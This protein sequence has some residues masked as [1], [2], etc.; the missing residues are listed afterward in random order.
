MSDL[1]LEIASKSTLVKEKPKNKTTKKEVEVDRPESLKLLEEQ[2]QKEQQ[3]LDKL[4]FKTN[5]ELKA[6]SDLIEKL[7][8]TNIKLVTCIGEIEDKFR[9]LNDSHI[10]VEFDPLEQVIRV[11]ES[12][13]A[14]LTKEI[15]YLRQENTNLT[16]ILSYTDEPLRIKDMESK[17]KLREEQNE[18]L[19]R[20]ISLESRTADEVDK[21]LELRNEQMSQN[22]NFK[23]IQLTKNEEKQELLKEIKMTG[24]SI[25][26]W[27]RLLF[28]F[29]NKIKVLKPVKEPE[30]ERYDGVGARQ[31]THAKKESDK[32]EMMNSDELLFDRDT[33]KAL[34][35][36]LREKDV[37]QLESK[38]Q[39]VRHIGKTDDKKFAMNLRLMNKKNSQLEASLGFISARVEDLGGLNK[40]MFVENA[41]LKEENKNKRDL[42][43]NC[44]IAMNDLNGKIEERLKSNLELN[45]EIQK[46]RESVKKRSTGVP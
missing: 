38:F 17:L 37:D 41:G 9:N 7:S 11:K 1:P 14:S 15:N 8:L 6:K 25:E 34:K 36:I 28:E 44:K 3:E 29:Q 10:K 26:S 21:Q 19:V 32:R 30:M 16:E 31:L 22:N 4:E 27:R 20:R 2:L 43:G 39:A 45:S 13:L 23:D 42:I 5:A 35:K 18:E 12:E 40:V 24:V 46:L 33:R